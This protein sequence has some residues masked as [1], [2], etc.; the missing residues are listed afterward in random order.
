MQR[1]RHSIM[2]A[3]LAAATMG[4]GLA[5]AHATPTAGIWAG[6]GAVLTLHNQGGRLDFDCGYAT[7]PSP[8]TPDRK[9]RFRTVGAYF[10]AQ[11][12]PVDADKPAARITAR[13][14]GTFTGDSL[15]IIF[16]PAGAATETFD[17]VPGRP[18]KLI[19]CM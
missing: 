6:N 10:P 2:R 13:I 18:R 15:R 9:G 7:L 16:T 17:L 1:A 4:L 11:A 12:G 8:I 5:D 3:V 19:R 14:E